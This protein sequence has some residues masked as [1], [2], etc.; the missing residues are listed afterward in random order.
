MSIL[1]DLKFADDIALLTH[2]QQDMYCKMEDLKA[3]GV[4]VELRMNVT[5]NKM[6]KVMAKHDGSVNTVQ[7]TVDEVEKSQ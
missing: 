6:M 1:E 2:R 5:K 3:S 7:E 4:K